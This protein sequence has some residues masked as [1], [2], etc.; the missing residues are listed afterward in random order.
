MTWPK[1]VLITLFV[2]TAL[3]NISKVGKPRPTLTG[4]QTAASVV[5]TGAMVW[6]VVIA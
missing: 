3:V 1:T 4:G 6:L 5:I 2:L